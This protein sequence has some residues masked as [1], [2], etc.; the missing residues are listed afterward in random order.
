MLQCSFLHTPIVTE[1]PS[2]L[3]FWLHFMM[4]NI[5]FTFA[6][7][8]FSFFFP[9]NFFRLFRT[10]FLL[11]KLPPPKSWRML[12]ICLS[13]YRF[14]L[15]VHF[16]VLLDFLV[17]FFSL[18]TPV[19]SPWRAIFFLTSTCRWSSR[20]QQAGQERDGAVGIWRSHLV[21]Y[22]QCW[23]FVLQGRVILIWLVP[24]KI[25]QFPGNGQ[26]P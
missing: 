4:P 3:G 23:P 20:W 1:C 11:R 14:V 16:H 12:W 21:P 17:R 24:F 2:F 26:W 13:K 18:Y 15:F 5:L 8:F 25:R 22:W 7:F 6:S 19:G 10:F 9:Q